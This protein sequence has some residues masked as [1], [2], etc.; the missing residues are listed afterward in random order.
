MWLA[1]RA[2]VVEDAVNG[3]KAAKAA[4][5]FTVGVTNSLPRHLLEPHADVVVDLIQECEQLLASRV[6]G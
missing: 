3:L 1:C 5:C 2:L 4:G 6:E